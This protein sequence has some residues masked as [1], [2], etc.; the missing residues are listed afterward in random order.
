MIISNSI[1]IGFKNAITTKV[2]AYGGHLTI[3]AL[4]YNQ[5]LEQQPIFV[6][7]E[8]L[9]I[10]K[11]NTEV[12]SF[13]AVVIKGALAK[14]ENNFEPVILKGVDHQFDFSFFS[15]YLVEGKI[16][17]YENDTANKSTDILVSSSW[18][19][20][21]GLKLNDKFLVYFIQN[22]ARVRKFK[23]CGIYSTGLE[24]FDGK[25]VFCDI[26]QLRKING[27]KNNMCS[28]I[29]IKLHDKKNIAPV[30]EVLFNQLPGDVD[31][32][33]VYESYPQIFDWL[34]LQDTNVLVIYA[35]ML[36]VSIVNII[37][38]L[39]VLILEKTKLISSLTV[40]GM[41][42]IK[43]K[44]VFLLLAASIG[45]RGM[46]A[47]SIFSIGILALQKQFKIVKLNAASYYIDY[48]PVE[49]DVLNIITVNLIT[50]LVCTFSMLLP[51]LIIKRISIIKT[52]QFQ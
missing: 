7:N 4:E 45:L 30:S 33:T 5:S 18:L 3:K 31:V 21:T 6:N 26:K 48:V 32:E 17:K 23:I 38:V 50:L 24:E 49:F 47:G 39:M 2:M 34:S 52:I 27:W 51:V 36:V 22:P 19:T 43:I 14:T 28:G 20:K 41:K 37:T 44:A 11:N 13:S 35:I 9:S 29:E 40:M 12:N 8:I 10:I 25:T 42:G 46:V 15:Q 1:L 16:P